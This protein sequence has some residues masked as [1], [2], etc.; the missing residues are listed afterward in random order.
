[1]FGK[2]RKKKTQEGWEKKKRVTRE[3]GN[4]GLGGVK[5]AVQK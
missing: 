3:G 2:N 4:T 5:E 1:M